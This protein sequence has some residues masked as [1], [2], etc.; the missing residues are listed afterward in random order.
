MKRSKIIKEIFNMYLYEG[1]GA[2]TI[3]KELKERGIEIKRTRS[4]KN[5]Q[6][7]EKVQY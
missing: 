6:I 4:G 7:G 1:K 5:Q 3:A 2:Y